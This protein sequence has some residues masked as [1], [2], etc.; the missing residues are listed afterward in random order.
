MSS[1]RDRRIGEFVQSHYWLFLACPIAIDLAAAYASGSLAG[2]D[3]AILASVSVAVLA[4][5]GAQLK[6]A[7]TF[8]RASEFARSDHPSRDDSRAARLGRAYGRIAF[9]LVE[10][11]RLAPIGILLLLLA[12]ATGVLAMALELVFE[13]FRDIARR[14]GRRIRLA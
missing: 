6:R 7:S 9:Q 12:V 14:V 2:Q 8:D 4:I 5:I 11:L 13:P 10:R 1:D 3:V